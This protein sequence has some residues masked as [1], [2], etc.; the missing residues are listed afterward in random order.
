MSALAYRGALARAQT[1]ML[2]L[3]ADTGEPGP[4][5][6]DPSPSVEFVARRLVIHEEYLIDELFEKL[7]KLLG[8]LAPSRRAE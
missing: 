8:R 1:D 2:E 6:W 3:L 5:P 4:T 7:G